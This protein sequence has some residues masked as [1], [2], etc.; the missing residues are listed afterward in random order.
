MSL[1]ML[2]KASSIALLHLTTWHSLTILFSHLRGRSWKCLIS[3]CEFIHLVAAAQAVIL[4]KALNSWARCA[5]GRVY[6]KQHLL[7]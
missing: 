5:F 2:R 6:M 4:A 3:A 7:R 1:L